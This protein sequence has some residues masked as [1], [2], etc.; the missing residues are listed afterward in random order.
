VQRER[1]TGPPPPPPPPRRRVALPPE[2][3]P[4]PWLLAL[5]LLVL[6]GILAAYLLSRDGDE[7]D[8]V[9]VPSVVGLPE[10]TAS[11]RLRQEGFAVR[12]SRQF[13]GREQGEVLRQD[14]GGG[15]EAPSGSIVQIAVS[16]G[17]AEVAVPNLRGLSEAAAASK[18]TALGLRSKVFR[19]QSREADGTVVAQSPSADERIGKGEEVRINV[20]RG[21]TQTTTTTATTTAAATTGATTTG[22]TTT[23][24]TTGAGGTTTGGTTT[25]P[26]RNVSVPDVVGLPLADAAAELGGVGVFADTYPVSSEDEAGTVVAQTPASGRSV[27]VGLA[28]RLNVSIGTGP[29][30]Q[31][32]VPD[33]TG[34]EQGRAR[35]R[36]NRANLTVRA[37]YRAVRDPNEVGVVLLQRPDAGVRIAGYAQVTV[38]V[39]RR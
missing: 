34:A 17:P 30:P 1:R 10:N 14:P 12:A 33:V 16:R 38:Y 28:V 26:P 5:L 37:I 15:S 6:G 4:W 24:T 25:A 36:L 20:S 11:E 7:P 39:G 8:R 2:R 23:G 32:T 13:S 19:V 9:A 27:V 21:V 29:R 31:R 18:L 22:A 3:N 35:D